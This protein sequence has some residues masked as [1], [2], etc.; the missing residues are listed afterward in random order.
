MACGGI[1]R[2]WN[3]GEMSRFILRLFVGRILRM[4]TG[5]PSFFSCPHSRRKAQSILKTTKMSVA[6][7]KR[8]WKWPKWVSQ[9]TIDFENGQNECRKPQ[10]I[11]KMA[12]KTH[13]NAM[14]FW[15]RPKWTI[16]TSSKIIK[17]R[18]RKNYEA[19]DGCRG[20]RNF[21]CR[22][23]HFRISS[24]WEYLIIGIPLCWPRSVRS[25]SPLTM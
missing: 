6:K 23:F 25:L 9:G 14:Q 12:K 11:L 15:K 2:K 18:I 19:R 1:K 21:L 10:T 3:G 17:Q 22:S 13:Y 7:A 8:F 5:S 24:N 4:G 16:T 20:P